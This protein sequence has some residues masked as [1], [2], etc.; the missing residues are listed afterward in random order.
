MP[1]L[2]Q[3]KYNNNNKDV[4]VKV[5][6]YIVFWIFRLNVIVYYTNSNA[7]MNN[8]RLHFNVIDSRSGCYANTYAHIHTHI[9]IYIY[10]YIYIYDKH[11]M[12]I[13]ILQICK[14]SV[15]TI[16]PTLLPRVWDFLT[17]GHTVQ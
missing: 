3:R 13:Y 15:F 8:V 7:T 2:G 4:I 14:R 9:H 10:I 16:K 11:W 1:N 5:I 12:H 6:D 17:H